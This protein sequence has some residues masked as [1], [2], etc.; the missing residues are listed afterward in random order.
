MSGV[1]VLVKHGLRGDGRIRVDGVRA[2]VLTDAGG[3]YAVADPAG[4]GDARVLFRR[5]Q[6]ILVIEQGGTFLRIAF[7]RGE[8]TFEWDG[9]PYH[10]GSMIRGEIRI[11]QETR[12]VARGVVTVTGLR[13][14]EVSSELLPILRALAWG[15]AVRSEFVGRDL[16][17]EPPMYTG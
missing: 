5:F 12:R 17:A 1:E 8:S 13:L 3:W 2:R 14:D 11:D 16:L 6:D 9:R 15:L 4:H 7:H 10:I